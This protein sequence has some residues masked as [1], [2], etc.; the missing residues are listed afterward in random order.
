MAQAK[1]LLLALPSDVLQRL[2]AGIP[3][4][5]HKSTAAACRTFR[6]V[7]TD[8]RFIARR[9]W[10]VEETEVPWRDMEANILQAFPDEGRI[11][12]FLN[13]GAA[14][15]RATNGSWSRFYVLEGTLDIVEGEGF[16]GASVLLG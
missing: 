2:L 9:L 6:A 7:I 1:S 8:P 11:V 3:L 12:V 13:N 10:T 4:A 14:F 5:D 16:A 15:E